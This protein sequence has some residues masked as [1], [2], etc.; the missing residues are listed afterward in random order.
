MR[1]FLFCLTIFLAPAL[2]AEDFILHNLHLQ[3]FQADGFSVPASVHSVHQDQ[4]GRLWIGTENGLFLYDGNG[5]Q[6]HRLI[7]SNNRSIPNSFAKRIV[8]AP[9]GQIWIG[10]WGGGIA[11]YD[12]DSHDF[13][14]IPLTTSESG[15][16]FDSKI[17]AMDFDH[18][19]R[20]WIGTFSS[21]LFRYDPH[22][23]ELISIHPAGLSSP[24]RVRIDT[25]KID[26]QNNVWY[27]PY[28]HDLVV[29]NADSLERKNITETTHRNQ[30]IKD[31]T[32]F[33]DG[34]TLVLYLSGITIYD[35]DLTAL[36]TLSFPQ[37]DIYGDGMSAGIY[38]GRFVVVGTG[39]GG[40]HWID[41]EQEQM[42][43]IPPGSSPGKMDP[44][45]TWDIDV[46]SNG[47]ILLG[48][49]TGVWINP[50]LSRN[51]WTIS[52]H[53]DSKLPDV[54]GTRAL[55]FDRP[56]DRLIFNSQENIYSIDFN[57]DLGK[58]KIAT[59]T[60]ITEL[61]NETPYWM[62]ADPSGHIW[63]SGHQRL[64]NI[65]SIQSGDCCET[66]DYRGATVLLPDH[67]KNILYFSGDGTGIGVLHETEDRHQ[68]DWFAPTDEYTGSLRPAISLTDGAHNDIWIGTFMDLA[69]FSKEANSFLPVFDSEMM[70]HPEWNSPF[71]SSVKVLDSN[72]LII[73]SSDGVWLANLNNDGEIYSLNYLFD[74]TGFAALATLGVFKFG[75]DSYGV[76]N[77]SGL[78]RF[79][80]PDLSYESLTSDDGYP[81]YTSKMGGYRQYADGMV[82][83]SG[84]HGPVLFHPENIVFPKSKKTLHVTEVTSFRGNN[85]KIW[86]VSGETL[87]F[88]YQD[89][90]IRFK[91][92]LLDPLGPEDNRYEIRLIGFQD[93]W[94][95]VGQLKEFSFTNLDAGQYQFEI[96]AVDG[97]AGG[98]SQTSLQFSVLPPW[99]KTWWA[100]TLY[101][102]IIL[103]SLLGYFMHLRRKLQREQE[104]SAKLREAD[105]LKSRFLS[106][107]EIKV[108]EATGDLKHAVEAL[109]IKNVELEV[110][111]QRAQDASRL[112][113]EFLA[114]MSHEIRTPMNG[115]LGFTQLLK[116]S[117]LDIDQ[118]EYVNTIDNSA[119]NLLSIINDIL[120]ISRIEAG[121]LIIDNTGYELRNCATEMLETLAPVAYEKNLDL[122]MEITSDLP[123]GLRGD[124]VRMR[125][126]MTNLVGNAI[127]FTDSG[128]VAILLRTG[129]MNG[130]DALEI[131]IE[132]TGRGISET[133]RERLFQ[134][135]ERGAT[136]V[137]K[138]VVGTGLGLVITKKLTEAMGGE[139][140]LD[141]KSGKGTRVTLLFPLLPDRNP[142][143]RYDNI[144]PLA[145]KQV[146]LV[147][148]NEA[149]RAALH[150]ML[151]HLGAE[152]LSS[153]NFDASMAQQADIVACTLTRMEFD[154]ADEKLAAMRRQIGE[155][156]P[157]ICF[158]SSMD[159]I[160]IRELGEAHSAL[161]VPRIVQ[162]PTLVRRIED[163]LRGSTDAVARSTASPTSGMMSGMDV[164]IADDNR[165]NRFFLKKMLE[166][167]GASVHEATDGREALELLTNENI[168]AEIALIDLH[169]PELSGLELAERARA[170]GVNIPLLVVSANVLPE[171]RK[172]ATAAGFDGYIL[173]P[174]EEDVL[175]DTVRRYCR[176]ELVE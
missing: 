136:D 165:I 132:D 40:I 82:I 104:I 103:G 105:T 117:Q 116:K 70:P 107:L 157:L 49:T 47:D 141:S 123:L 137:S 5:V 41:P 102:F 163:W 27:E 54:T 126:V 171:T 56:N 63:V 78:I 156:K 1:L 175:V 64:T 72:R 62:D 92:G 31:I 148:G 14:R 166:T 80:L 115:V 11:R 125:Q 85:S 59:G 2:Q 173:K 99:W 95:D 8:E 159:R 119:H 158:V 127:K 174:V 111:Q 122:V 48:T 16:E 66:I 167:H 20:L 114:N 55:H 151:L 172:A 83:F 23:D 154:K 44:S 39:G 65:S 135:F 43:T 22:S 38:D 6:V 13:Q 106:E 88:E 130:E 21:G 93:D 51:F 90:V 101:A 33:P 4:N 168:N 15:I 76:F 155:D 98:V 134:A 28:K 73:T 29:I 36:T 96:R 97:Q 50:A 169:M 149:S 9:D 112:K 120:D 142:E 118:V 68:L 108:D 74:E 87:I 91:Y 160:R 26:N 69:R 140:N 113:S 75:G 176:R 124:P 86:P 24:R 32:I 133:D 71:I 143:N 3:K 161:C 67:E 34:R 79:N 147:D 94:I 131:V 10:T 18:K 170:A 129:I 30:N 45:I 84:D 164:I 152:I 146:H 37:G 7:R 138:G 153:A 89:R 81:S 19:G 52:A 144:Q 17:W 42:I 46:T 100:Y 128:H 139:I 77:S 162:L 109:E 12:N 35:K 121:K 58:P 53:Q 150:K 60:R 57:S 61:T 25:L 145:G 110:A